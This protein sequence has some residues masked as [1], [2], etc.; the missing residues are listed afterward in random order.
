MPLRRSSEV[1][2]RPADDPLDEGGGDHSNGPPSRHRAAS[3]GGL[4]RRPNATTR[5]RSSERTAQP[6]AEP[7]RSPSP[8]VTDPHN[9]PRQEFVRAARPRGLDCRSDL[10]SM[11]SRASV[12]VRA[13]PRSW[14]CG[15]CRRPSRGTSDHFSSLI[16]PASACALNVVVVKGG[17]PPS[18][19]TRLG[20]EVSIASRH[21]VPETLPSCSPERHGT[22]AMGERKRPVPVEERMTSAGHAQVSS[23]GW[24]RLSLFARVRRFR[25]GEIERIP[26][27]TWRQPWQSKL[28]SSPCRC[29]RGGDPRQSRLNA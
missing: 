9:T 28:R 3:A 21:G 24:P 13:D 14:G 19:V 25:C 20:L 6:G 17:E 15:P 27:K 12:Q 7:F 18:V 29:G 22:T 23:L 8:G 10:Q 4:R 2:V 5:F 26:L 1:H 16:F 11:L